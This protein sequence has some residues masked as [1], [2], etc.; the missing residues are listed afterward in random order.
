MK[1]TCDPVKRETTL[2]ERGLDFHDAATVFMGQTRTLED[3]RFDYGETRYQSYGLLDERVVMVVGTP[4]GGARHIISMR[5]C[6]DK[7]ARKVREHLG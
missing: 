5:H 1:I 6:H 4:R 3:D 2:R 7:Q